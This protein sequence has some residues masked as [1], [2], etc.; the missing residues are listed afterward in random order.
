MTFLP[1]VQRE[2][3]VA[4]RQRWTYA[5]R[6][7]AAGL[8]ALVAG[9][10]LTFV[11]DSGPAGRTLPR[12]IFNLLA[13]LAFAGALL[14]GLLLTTDAITAE[15]REGTLG[16]LFLTE[17]TGLDIILGK[18]ASCGIQGFCALL[19]VLPILAVP[20]MMGGVSWTDF[21]CTALL[22]GATLL[23]SAGIGLWASSRAHGVLPAFSLAL[24]LL[25]ALCVGPM[26][27][28]WTL[29]QAGIFPPWA[30]SLLVLSPVVGLGRSIEAGLLP[31]RTDVQALSAALATAL[32]GALALGAAAWVLN[33]TGRTGLAGGG[34]PSPAGPAGPATSPIPPSVHPG[35]RAGENAYAW[36]L[37]RRTP[38][39]RALHWVMELSYVGTV[40][41]LGAAVWLP[42]QTQAIPCFIIAMFSAYACHVLFK[43]Y[44]A[45]L[46]SAQLVEDAA[47][48][49]LEL[50]L[51]TPFQPAEILAGQSQA[52]RKATKSHLGALVLLN[53]ALVAALTDEELA[54]SGSDFNPFLAL[55][56]GG[57]V[58]LWVDRACLIRRGALQAL[59][60][61]RLNNAL[62]R[63]LLPVLG[64]PWMAALAIFLVATHGMSQDLAFTL[65]LIAQTAQVL[66]TWFLNRRAQGNLEQG[67]LLGARPRP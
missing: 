48:G 7:V 44:T 64:Q 10:L 25:G 15:R 19:G 39:L 51:C 58:H 12:L 49:G 5:V 46:S 67:F 18:L 32:A 60:S 14:G 56:L 9:L 29:N 45:L 8:L 6:C 4:G 33:Q 22:L 21:W 38:P 3:T 43:L 50:L 59:R 40:A 57:I 17:L 34:R 55:F 52:V 13:C 23:C 41:V 37:R 26:L 47:G 1:V 24:L 65:F 61:P 20:L 31:G 27:P 2:L 11:G 42:T 54:I 16:L 63:T 36:L 30:D 35:S 53:L 28:K 62:A 66:A